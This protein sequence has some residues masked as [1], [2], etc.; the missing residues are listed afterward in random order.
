MTATA[1]PRWKVDDLGQGVHLFRWPV[2]LYVS[3]FVVTPEGV[4]AIDPVDRTAAAAY[5]QAIASVTDAPVVAIIYSH[6]HRDHIVGADLLDPEAMVVAHPLTAQRIERR[7]DPDIRRPTHLLEEGEV[8]RFGPVAIETHYWGPNHADSNVPL[9]VRTDAG[10]M[11]IWVDGVEPGAAPYRELPDTDF[12][13]LLDSIDRAA[14]LQPDVL[15]G[16]HTLPGDPAW[17]GTH[18]RYFDALLVAAEAEYRGMGGQTLLPGEDPVAMTERVRRTTCE[19][20][21]DRVRA[22]FGWMRGFD[23]WA[24]KN[25]DRILTY[26]ITGN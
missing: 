14:S 25:A 18:R 6:D 13:G 16:G 19:Q 2:G 23:Q 17:L 8:L 10:R 26:L 3:C 4:V 5:R 7:N 24:P 12:G 20:A 11:L 9:L 15:I 1:P 22:E 21:A